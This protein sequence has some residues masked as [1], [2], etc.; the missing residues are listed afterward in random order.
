[1]RSTAGQRVT[2]RARFA[3]FSIAR[4]PRGSCGR[5]LFSPAELA[6]VFDAAQRPAWAWKRRS[7]S[8]FESAS[9]DHAHT[10]SIASAAACHCG[11]LHQPDTADGHDHAGAARTAARSGR[12][13]ASRGPGGAVV[14][15]LGAEIRL[16]A[17]GGAPAAA[18]GAAR[19]ALPP[20][21]AGHAMGAGAAF[22]GD[23][24]SG[25][26]QRRPRA[27]AG[28]RR[29]GAGAAHAGSAGVIGRRRGL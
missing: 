1:M 16:G 3:P 17:V 15:A 25:P 10:H 13:P 11:H 20:A 8:F 12:L 18:A 29:V 19:A 21:A 4:N 27:H 9:Q 5:R 7:E 23:G 2:G 24:R 22:A 14:A 6:P 28:R 26:G